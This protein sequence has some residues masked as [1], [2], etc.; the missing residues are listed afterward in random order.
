[1]VKLG[2]AWVSSPRTAIIQVEMDTGSNRCCVGHCYLMME[3]LQQA[4]AAY[5]AALVNLPNPK[6]RALIPFCMLRFKLDNSLAN[7]L[8]VGA[9]ALV[10][11]RYSL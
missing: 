8:A 11:H 1:M 7:C 2:A 3:D 6:V 10:W 4:Y 5:Q 9:E